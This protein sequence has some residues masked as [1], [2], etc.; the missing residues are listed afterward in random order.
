VSK[1][2]MMD[3]IKLPEYECCGDCTFDVLDVNL[4]NGPAS[5]CKETAEFLR[6][7]V[8][9]YKAKPPR[10]Y[11][12]Q[13]AKISCVWCFASQIVKLTAE[14]AGTDKSEAFLVGKYRGRTAAEVYTSGD[15]GRRYVESCAEHHP[16]ERQ[17][18]LAKEYLNANRLGLCG[19]GEALVSGGSDDAVRGG[20]TE[21][22]HNCGTQE[23]GLL[24]AAETHASTRWR[25]IGRVE[26]DT[27]RDQGGV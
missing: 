10:R 18:Q 16:V 15:D 12:K 22:L 21:G 6:D 24:A 4:G 9:V 27:R 1:E 26:P 25:L 13:R 20:G 23:R 17:H 7:V 2:N 8:T 14:I 11:Y 19:T 3:P 5:L